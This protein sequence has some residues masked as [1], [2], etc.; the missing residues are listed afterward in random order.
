M[1]LCLSH[2]FD[3]PVARVM[4]TLS[5]AQYATH[6]AA[7]HSF[8]HEIEV[9]RRRESAGV[10]ERS[11]R[12]RARP[13]ITRLGVFS[14]PATWFS[15][16]E[17]SRFD[18]K[19]GLL[20]FDNVPEVESVRAKLVNRGSMQFDAQ[21]DA[22]GHEHTRRT[23]TFELAFDVPALYRPLAELGLALVARQLES[24]LDEEAA[25]LAAWLAENAAQARAA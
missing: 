20:S 8:F 4:R 17:Q 6:L 15:W 9:L 7:H 24:S 23:A 21:V 14:L 19:A 2:R 1:K 25:L 3:A 12:Y 10:V 11:V 5:S 16:V 13:F 22:R 18:L